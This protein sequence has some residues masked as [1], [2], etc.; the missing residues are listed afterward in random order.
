[1]SF[2]LSVIASVAVVVL[3]RRFGATVAAIVRRAFCRHT[4]LSVT[5]GPV[6]FSASAQAEVTIEATCSRCGELWHA[7]MDVTQSLRDG[8]GVT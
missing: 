3:W 5:C 2:A 8:M 7:P 1:M 4:V 6:S